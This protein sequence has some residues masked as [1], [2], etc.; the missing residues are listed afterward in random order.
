MALALDLPDALVRRPARARDRHHAGHQLRARARRA[1]SAA[2]ARCAWARTP[3][4]ACSRSCSPTT[5]P[6]SRCSATAAWHDVAAPRGPFVCNLGDMLDRWTNDRWT[7]TLHRVVPPPPSGAGP[8]RRRSIARFLDCPPDLVVEMHPDVRRRRATPRGTNRSS[9][10]RGCAQKILGGR[11][12]LA[13][14]DLGGGG[15]YDRS[16]RTVPDEIDALACEP[17]AEHGFAVVRGLYT[18]A[19]LDALQAELEDLQ[20]RLVAGELPEACGTVILDDPDAVIDGE[21][22]AH[23]VCEITPVSARAR[24][25]VMHP[26]VVDAVQRLLGPS[27][28]LLEDDRFGVVY[29]DAR[30]GERSGYSRIGWHSDAQSG[31]NLDWWPSVAFTIHL[32]ATSPAE[33]LPARRARL[34]PRRHR[35]HAARVRE[36]ARRDRACTATAA[37]CCC[38]TPT[39]GTARPAPPTTARAASA[40]TSAAAGTAAHAPPPNTASTTSSRTPAANLRRS[41]FPRPSRA[42]IDP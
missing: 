27:A 19:E 29:Q 28:W 24:A 22:F 41:R 32:D 9:P 20:R 26:V 16:A 13:P 38:T 33:R 11:A 40:A 3:T 42:S 2:R 34:A 31:P 15:A 17:F 23:Y 7:S 39:S 18:D 10:A 6:A 36:G 25:A 1:R 4:T 30:P 35:R 5:C 8:V 14:P 37:T 12:R 21:P